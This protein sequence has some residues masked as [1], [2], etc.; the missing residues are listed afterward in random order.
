LGRRGG[1][2]EPAEGAA[3]DPRA[4]EPSEAIAA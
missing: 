2:S 4:E 1:P 3:D